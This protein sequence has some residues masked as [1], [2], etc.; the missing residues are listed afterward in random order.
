MTTEATVVIKGRNDLSY[1]VK[2]AERD[3]RGL[4]KQGE[5]L[6]KLFRGG[7][8][9]AAIY[10]FERFAEAAQDA[11]EQ[12][13]DKGTAK[14]LKSLNREID[15]LKAK[16]TNILGK[17]LG[18]V[19]TAFRGDELDKIREQIDFLERMQ[20]RSFVAAGYGR[21]GTGFFTPEE[22]KAK[23]E[24]LKKLE[25]LYAN[26]L[27]YKDRQNAPGSHARGTGIVDLA[28]EPK[29][30]S[31]TAAELAG[32]SE[33]AI[34]VQ[35][36]TTSATEQL[37]RDMDEATQT[38][39]QQQLATW[40]DFDTQVQA[41]VEAGRITQADASQRIIENNAKYLEEIE[42]T[43]EKIY[44]QAERQ[45]L[46]VFADEAARGM[47]DAFANFL[48]DPFSEG[49]DGMLAGFADTVR[50]MIAEAAA[51]EILQQFFGF[52]GG[53]VGGKAGAFLGSMATSVGHRASGGPVSAGKPYLVGERGAELFIP[54]ASG[55]IVPNGAMGAVTV[56]YAID[57]R[58]A[59]AERIMAVLPGMLER[60]KGQTIAEI[61]RLMRQGRLTGALT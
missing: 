40:Q 20:G 33:I 18:N 19:Y 4:L 36:I 53:L 61:T 5:L 47:Q 38:S 28:P 12:L 39:M 51:A 54:R 56:N 27:S 9:A 1:A 21:I 31:R 13:G 22:A 6:G 60:T 48:F 23:L 49:L 50:R 34:T 44:P 37:Y 25:E 45:Q 58:G 14:A 11:A 2:S 43:A 26:N 15:N 55:S 7:A 52:L 29:G 17:V 42:I 46:N 59:D 30:P 10:S 16:G 24:E 57:A 3:L 35:R 32:L 8:I 41:L